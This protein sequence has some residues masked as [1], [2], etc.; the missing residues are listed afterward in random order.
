MIPR[1]SKGLYRLI[2]P[3]GVRRLISYKQTVWLESPAATRP[4]QLVA[5]AEMPVSPGD[6]QIDSDLEPEREKPAIS[7]P[8][9]P[10]AAPQMS[11]GSQIV[12][13]KEVLR[14]VMRNSHT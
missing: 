5:K 8:P 9:P 7:P 6:R 2:G 10:I 1:F 3:I 11:L 14:L 12:N 13:A 4:L